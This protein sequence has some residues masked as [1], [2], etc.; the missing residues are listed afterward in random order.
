MVNRNA[1]LTISQLFYSNHTKRILLS[2]V[3]LCNLNFDWT[4]C[5]VNL[6]P[7]YL[8]FWKISAFNDYM[9]FYGYTS[10]ASLK[11]L[12]T[13]CTH[14]LFPRLHF[15]KSN[16]LTWWSLIGRMHYSTVWDRKKSAP[17]DSVSFFFKVKLIGSSRFQRNKKIFHSFICL[18]IT[19][20]KLWV[21]INFT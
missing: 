4:I 19:N 11:K 2:F 17:A 18:F 9:P 7:V 12:F 3:P 5:L 21:P 20:M 13:K 6:P 8:P 1:A 14:I 10:E 15:K 16:H